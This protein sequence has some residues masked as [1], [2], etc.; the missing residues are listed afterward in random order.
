MVLGLHLAP[1]IRHPAIT[2][3]SQLS[4]NMS[5]NCEIEEGINKYIY[6][7]ELKLT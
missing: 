7:I 5:D 2:P 6:K 1:L 4:N 3:A